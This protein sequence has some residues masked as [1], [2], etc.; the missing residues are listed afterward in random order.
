MTNQNISDAVTHAVVSNN[1]ILQLVSSNILNRHLSFILHL[2]K[3]KQTCFNVFRQ[4]SYIS[5]KR[6]VS[7]LKRISLLLECISKATK[8][9][10]LYYQVRFFYAVLPKQDTSYVICYNGEDGDGGEGGC[11][12]FTLSYQIDA[13]ISCV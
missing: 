10:D 5:P 7:I 9:I 12:L 2:K 8:R 11:S 13:W 6:K 3:F 1:R 4:I